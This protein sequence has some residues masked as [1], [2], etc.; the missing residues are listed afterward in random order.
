MG[1]YI[2]Q[3]G[4]QQGPYEPNE[5]NAHGITPD[6]PVWTDGMADWMPAH[7]V[8]ALA[9]L[10]LAMQENQPQNNLYARQPYPQPNFQ[11]MPPQ[12]KTWLIEAILATELSAN[13]TTA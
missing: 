3:N 6:T 10:F 13:A 8:A 1:Y 4:V 11:Q 5:L 9:F 12:P 7:D 2:N